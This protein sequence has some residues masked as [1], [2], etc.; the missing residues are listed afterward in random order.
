MNTSPSVSG[1]LFL[2]VDVGTQGSKAGLYTG[3]GVLVADTYAEHRF[4]HLRPG[5]VE[6][7]ADWVSVRPI[8]PFLATYQAIQ[9]VRRS[10]LAGPLRE[11]FAVIAP[12]RSENA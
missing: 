6:M 5:W 11:A 9:S 10:I 7:D 4:D 2:G 3:D 12:L 8:I 1:D